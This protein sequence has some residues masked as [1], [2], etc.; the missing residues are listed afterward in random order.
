VELLS[1]IDRLPVRV[2]PRG[3]GFSLTY[4]NFEKLVL[5]VVDREEQGRPGLFWE[6]SQ[7]RRAIR[8]GFNLNRT[9]ALDK[10]VEPAHPAQRAGKSIQTGRAKLA[11][12]I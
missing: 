3:C 10:V 5:G 8:E 4:L 6:D 7:A 9:P 11:E 12:P 1:T 2:L